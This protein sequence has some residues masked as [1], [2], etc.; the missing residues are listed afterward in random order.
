MDFNR[1]ISLVRRL[2]RVDGAGA[3]RSSVLVAGQH[4]PDLVRGGA[5]CHASPASA[6]ANLI[7]AHYGVSHSAHCGRL[8]HFSFGFLLAHP[9]EELF[10]M[11]SRARGWLVYYLPV[12]TVLGLS[13]LWEI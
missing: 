8:V 7:R 4:S 12:I 3:G 13:G 11:S 6:F 5:D 2:I 10:R 1:I 9:I